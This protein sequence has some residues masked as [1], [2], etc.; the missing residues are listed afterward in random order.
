[1]RRMTKM[2]IS[3]DVAADSD[4]RSPKLRSEEKSL[5]NAAAGKIASV[6]VRA[7]P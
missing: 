1:M 3:C 7:L 2:M 6:A 4:E 5:E